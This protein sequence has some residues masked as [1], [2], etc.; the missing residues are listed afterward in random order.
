[1]STFGRQK[2]SSTRG[3]RG[4]V[5]PGPAPARSRPKGASTA[6][7]G[8]AIVAV[9]AVVVVVLAYRVGHHSGGPTVGD[10]SEL[11]ARIDAIGGQVNAMQA[12]VDN[13]AAQAKVALARSSR[14]AK[15]PAQPAQPLL[16][17]CLTQVQ[18][19]V[20]DLQA[21]LA[22]GTRPRRDRVSGPCLRLLNPRFRG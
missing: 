19:E 1:M 13:A 22:Y 21:Y 7:A 6:M 9:L 11:E 18:R 10:V 4:P 17:T 15:Q 14:P 2:H 3:P 20:D 16:A 5:A 8:T 12:T